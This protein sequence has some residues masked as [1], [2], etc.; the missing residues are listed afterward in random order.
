MVRPDEQDREGQSQTE[1]RK[2]DERKLIDAENGVR[3][4]LVVVRIRH[5]EDQG[6]DE[7]TADEEDTAENVSAQEILCSVSESIDFLFVGQSRVLDHRHFRV[8]EREGRVPVEARG[9][10]H[11][12]QCVS[13]CS[14]KKKIV[15]NY[16]LKFLSI[17]K[18]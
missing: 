5:D 16:F 7:G 4:Q 17:C 6:D 11:G 13:C 18:Q 1:N 12:P 3:V 10:K 8:A 2:K 9:H 14:V 15:E